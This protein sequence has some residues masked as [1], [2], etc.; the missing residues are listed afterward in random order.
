MSE[1]HGGTLSIESQPS[2]GTTVSV[3]FPAE[4]TLAAGDA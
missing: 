4:R 3:Q 2:H 1:I